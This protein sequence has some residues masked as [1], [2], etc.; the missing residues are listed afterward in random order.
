MASDMGPLIFWSTLFGA[1]A[2][3]YCILLS[4]AAGF[5][6]AVWGAILSTRSPTKRYGLRI[7]KT[8]ALT[9]LVGAIV[10]IALSFVLPSVD[11]MLLAWPIGPAFFGWG[12]IFPA[13]L[14]FRFRNR[15]LEEP[16]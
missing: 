8:G 3:A 4:A 12:A 9:L 5:L 14:H 6:L 11:R 10:F 2:V 1:A 16:I 13:V 15:P 7:L